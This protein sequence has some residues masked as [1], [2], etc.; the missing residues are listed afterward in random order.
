MRTKSNH[1]LIK[2]PRLKGDLE[3]ILFLLNLKKE[4]FVSELLSEIKRSLPLMSCIIIKKYLVYL[5]DYE[6]ILYKGQS[7][8]YQI[9]DNGIDLLYFI[10]KEK[11][12]KDNR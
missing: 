4:L 5:A 6:L 3:N 12:V 2:S 8:A 9:E 7:H 10:A 11:E 1:L